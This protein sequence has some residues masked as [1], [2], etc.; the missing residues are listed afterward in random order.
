MLQKA[1]RDNALPIAMIGVAFGLLLVSLVGG[2]RGFAK[3]S[4]TGSRNF[5]QQPPDT[6]KPSASKHHA[7]RRQLSTCEPMAGYGA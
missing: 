7:A 1:T 2:Q 3:W 6:G 4:R 5:R